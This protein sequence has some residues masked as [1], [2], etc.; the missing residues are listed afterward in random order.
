MNIRRKRLL[1]L[2][3]VLILAQLIPVTKTNPVVDAR[4]SLLASEGLPADVSATLRR[5]CQDCHSNRTAWPWYSRVAP[6]SWVVASDVN[7]GRH[8]LNF[9]EWGAYDLEKKQSRLTKVCEELKSGDMPDSKYLWI[10]RGAKLTQQQR[11]AL[12]DWAETTRR[13]IINPAAGGHN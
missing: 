10:H 11:A 13:A 5:S 3:G 9:D 8:H 12:C 1:I 7:G 2:A 4:S 6:V